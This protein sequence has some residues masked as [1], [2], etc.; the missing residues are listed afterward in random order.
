MVLTETVP[1]ALPKQRSRWPFFLCLALLALIVAYLL[2]KVPEWQN[3]EK[4]AQLE[5]RV[6]MLP[7]PPDTELDI[8]SAMQGTVGIQAANGD[9]CDYLVRMPLL[10]TLPDAEIARYY[11]SAAV[12]GVAGRKLSGTVYVNP[13]GSRPDGFKDVIVEFFDT[14]YDPGFDVRCH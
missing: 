11:E 3:D 4:L 9:H 10:T 7:L 14:G 13:S 6:H 1:G 12:E 5:D 8:S 2:F